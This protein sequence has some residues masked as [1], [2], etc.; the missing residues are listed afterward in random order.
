MLS[1]RQI[2]LAAAGLPVVAQQLQ[3]DPT[4][5]PEIPAA[6][7]AP[8]EELPSPMTG[9]RWKI[10]F[11]HDEA[12]TRML[13]TD[14]VAPAP[15]FALASGMLAGPRR[16]RPQ[17][18]GLISR[19]GGAKWEFVKLPGPP[20]SLFALDPDHVWLVSGTRL[21]VTNDQ[22]T[23]WR[24]LSLP[25]KMVRVTFLTPQTGFAFGAGKTFHRTS[26]G[27]Q[28][29]TPVPEG[30]DLKLTDE[31]TFFRVMSFVDGRVGVLAGNSRR[32]EDEVR[33]FPDWMI[34]EQA[35]RRRPKPA[36]LAVL[37]SQDGGATW[38]SSVASAFGDVE[39][40]HLRGSRG[41]MLMSYGEGFVWPSEVFRT[42]LTT[43]KSEPVFRR[44][45]LRV[46]DALLL[47]DSGFLLAVIEPF[48][49]LPGAGLPGRLCL[50]YSPDGRRWFQMPVD[51][52][53]QGPHALLAAESETRIH[54]ALTNGMILTLER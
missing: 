15:G 37:T 54:A 53:A 32:P 19:N 35:L 6:P 13:L 8:P 43:G 45:S 26:D 44:K 42:D 40:L 30:K 49:Q 2:L 22:G 33:E 4:K 31:N 50:V 38:D 18:F 52:R 36:S 29:W 10:G 25:K 28:R 1:R 23:K 9:A 39:R 5:V 20:S 47:G 48:G 7:P 34:P 24:R 14:L 16:G 3:V 27:G 17:N 41:A 46:A 21:Y 11:F 12:D 51:Y